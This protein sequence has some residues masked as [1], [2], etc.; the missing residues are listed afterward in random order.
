MW[1]AG[2][3]SHTRGGETGGLPLALLVLVPIVHIAHATG[4]RNTLGLL[5]MLWAF[6]ILVRKGGRPPLAVPVLAWLGIVFASSIWSVDTEATL[7][8]G[9]TDVAMPMGAFYAAFLASRQHQA[10]SVLSAA[11]ASGTVLLAVLTVVALATDSAAG[12]QSEGT[13]GALYY[14]PGP[15][16]ASTLG[17]YALPFALLLSSEADHRARRRL[18]FLSLGCIVITG[19]G[20]LNRMFWPALIVTSA[21][22]AFWYWP[23]LSSSKRAWFTGG[24]LALGLAAAGIV[25]YLDQVR[26]PPNNVYSMRLQAFREWS[27]SLAERPLLGQGY[28]RKILPQAAADNLSPAL[29]EDRYWRSHAHNLFLNVLLQ[30]G[31]VGLGTLLLLVGCLISQACRARDATRLSTSAALVSL[32]VAMITK[33]LTDDFMTQAVALAFWIYAG[34]LAGRISSGVGVIEPANARNGTN[35]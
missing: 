15:G 8:G 13:A 9:L 14:Y 3:R 19:A 26:N 24:L 16:V 12:L 29:A 10:F 20:T 34:I 32:V 18:G 17:V 2:L 21:A 25:L 7:K 22:F 5:I 35:G 27:R 33:N 4:L 30:I 23:R 1:V 11:A 28:G 6:L 31:I